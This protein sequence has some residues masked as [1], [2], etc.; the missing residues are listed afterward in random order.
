MEIKS[1]KLGL[2]QT[3]CFVVSNEGK[4]IV[5]DPGSKF[6]KLEPLLEGLSVKAILLTHGH[7][8]HIGIVDEL[9]QKYQCKVYLHEEDEDMV[10]TSQ[11]YLS[12]RGN[13]KIESPIVHLKEGVIVIANMEINVIFTPGH[14]DGSV[15][16]MIKNN[17]FSGDTLFFEDIGRTDLETSSDRKMKASIKYLMTLDENTIVYPGHGQFTTIQHELKSNPYLD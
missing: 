16:F 9:Y 10:R 6:E 2:Y 17:L 15:C 13:V 4:A 11:S 12:P 14:S 5:I 7:F 8:D 3:N 1:V